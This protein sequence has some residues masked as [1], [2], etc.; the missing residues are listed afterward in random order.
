MDLFNLFKKEMGMLEARRQRV[1]VNV[2]SSCVGEDIEDLEYTPK[3]EFEGYFKVT[4]VKNEEELIK[5]W[6]AHMEEEKPGIY[7]TYNGDFF[8][9]PFME[10]RAAHHVLIIKT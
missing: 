1:K 5:S 9:W 3:V 6:F 2:A 4:N 10:R 7:V 8:D